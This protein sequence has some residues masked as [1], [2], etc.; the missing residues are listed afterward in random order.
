LFRC[1]IGLLFGLGFTYLFKLFGDVFI[2]LLL[3]LRKKESIEGERESLGLG[4][5]DFMGMVGAFL[6]IQGV[7]LVFFIAPFFAVF[8]SIFALIFKKS[9]LIPY[10]PY[11]SLATV[12]V[13]FWGRNIWSFIF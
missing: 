1:F 11:L 3:Y 6:G 4:D 5:I 13:F 12:V 2:I 10:L 9:H 8:Y 7:L